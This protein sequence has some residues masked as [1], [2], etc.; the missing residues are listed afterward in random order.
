MEVIIIRN[1]LYQIKRKPFITIMLIF[2]ITFVMTF[3]SITY[4]SIKYN[5]NVAQLVNGGYD[6]GKSIQYTLVKRPEAQYTVT[7]DNIN[8]EVIKKILENCDM[9]LTVHAN[10]NSA[11]VNVKVIYSKSK[12]Q[13]ILYNERKIKEGEFN[14]AYIGHNLSG[15]YKGNVKVLGKNYEI[16]DLMGIR[17]MST[18][19]DSIITIY[20]NSIEELLYA[21]NNAELT[22]GASLDLYINN[23]NYLTYDQDIKSAFKKDQ[24]YTRNVTRKDKDWKE[25]KEDNGYEYISLIIIGIISILSISTFWI[26]DRRRD[27]AIKRAFGAKNKYV[28]LETYK[29]LLVMWIF[30]GILGFIISLIVSTTSNKVEAIMISVDIRDFINFFLYTIIASLIISILPLYRAVKLDI[31]TN[32][33]GR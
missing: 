17:G 7:E 9:S 31:V 32:I 26:K 13:L 25:L 10:I 24:Y 15:E 1:I 28:I 6:D 3:I 4:S 11:Q 33:K 23:K 2:V 5:R 21:I 14:K 27:I 8:K 16:G 12:P 29:E 30:C 20:V 19:L 22:G 18:N